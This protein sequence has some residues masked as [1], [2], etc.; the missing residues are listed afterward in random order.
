MCFKVCLA[1]GLSLLPIALSITTT[2]LLLACTSRISKQKY[3]LLTHSETGNSYVF[4]QAT[5]FLSLLTEGP[6]PQVIPSLY[7]TKRRVLIRVN[8]NAF[9]YI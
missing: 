3:Y 4:T 8:S 6:R 2:H 9:F 7:F 1:R 5:L